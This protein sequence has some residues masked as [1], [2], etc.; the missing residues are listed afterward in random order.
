M[1]STG[2]VVRDTRLE[3]NT[4][5]GETTI[6]SATVDF[7]QDTFYEVVVDWAATTDDIV[8]TL[9]RSGAEV[10]TLRAAKPSEAPSSGGIGFFASGDA[11]W[12]F[13]DV[14]LIDA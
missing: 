12:V 13:D 9:F 4:T 11:A 7:V 6:A 5:D 3:H 14:R 2:G 1:E 10:A 8:V